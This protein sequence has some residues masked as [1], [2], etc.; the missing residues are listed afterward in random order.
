M[1]R[2]DRTR[3][4]QKLELGDEVQHEFCP[5]SGATDDYCSGKTVSFATAP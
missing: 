3:S 4:A 1:G 5:L 2:N